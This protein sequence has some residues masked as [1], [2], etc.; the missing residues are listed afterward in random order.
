MK[1]V[2]VT[3]TAVVDELVAD[4]GAVVLVDNGGQHRVLRLSVMGQVV[5]EIARPGV[6]LGRL[7]DELVDRFG[8]AGENPADAV[9]TLVR[10]LESAG[11]VRVD[12]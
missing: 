3:S 2:T 8:A 5:R 6:S 12:G 1:D 11:L 9:A 4:D 7:T 10:D